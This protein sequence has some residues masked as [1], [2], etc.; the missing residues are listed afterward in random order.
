MEGMDNEYLVVGPSEK[1]T[2]FMQE[3]PHQPL[4]LGLLVP[5]PPLHLPLCPPLVNPPN[6]ASYPYPK[7]HYVPVLSLTLTLTFNTSRLTLTLGLYGSVHLGPMRLREY[8][9]M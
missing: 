7:S 3:G 2:A 5:L 8:V 4:L 6:P 1:G 9:D